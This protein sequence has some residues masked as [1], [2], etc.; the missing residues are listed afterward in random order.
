MQV[1]SVPHTNHVPQ[2]THLQKSKNRN[3]PPNCR[4]VPAGCK[5]VQTGTFVRAGN[6]D[7]SAYITTAPSTSQATV[8]F[9]LPIRDH[10]YQLV[11]TVGV[12]ILSWFLFC[13]V[14]LIYNNACFCNSVFGLQRSCRQAPAEAIQEVDPSRCS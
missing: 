12:F 9:Q 3:H 10:R 7:T 1:L 2:T 8:N 14:S 11:T 6:P 5:V 4:I 13:R